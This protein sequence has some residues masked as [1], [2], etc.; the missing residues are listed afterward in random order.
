VELIDLL[1]FRAKDRKCFCLF[2]EIPGVGL[3]AFFSV[4]RY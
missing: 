1:S 4:L 2:E 3:R